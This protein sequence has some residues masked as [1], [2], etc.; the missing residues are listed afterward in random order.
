MKHHSCT[1]S[2]AHSLAFHDASG[3]FEKQAVPFSVPLVGLPEEYK[4]QISSSESAVPVFDLV[5]AAITQAV[6]LSHAPQHSV[7][8]RSA[9][10]LLRVIMPLPL[11]MVAFEITVQFGVAAQFRFLEVFRQRAERHV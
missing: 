10:L 7:V 4:V 5:M 9:A 6:E 2:L 3:P 8:A 1:H 11:P